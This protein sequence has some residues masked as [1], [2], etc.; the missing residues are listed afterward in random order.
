[1]VGC[2]RVCSRCLVRVLGTAVAA[3]AVA[4]CLGARVGPPVIGAQAAIY[5]FE[6]PGHPGPSPTPLPTATPRPSP[7]ATPRPTP[8]PTPAPT[9]KPTEPPAP[10]P[11]P[12]PTHTPAPPP[13]PART[14][15]PTAAPDT[16]T[17]AA[18]TPTPAPTTPAA[19][20]PP[21]PTPRATPSVVTELSAI[22]AAVA[23]YAQDGQGRLS[24]YVVGADAMA[25]VAV[26]SSLALAVL[27]RRGLL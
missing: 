10:T 13:A 1:M 3:T 12:E 7:T 2:R 18:P 27:R 8:P 11:H 20:A 26:A 24:P 23:S 25:G 15:E 5:D 21:H 16:P 6:S 14:S 9:P 19:A 4:A 22:P 17:A